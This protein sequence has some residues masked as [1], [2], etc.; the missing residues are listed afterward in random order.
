MSLK[1]Q[2][3]TGAKAPVDAPLRWVLRTAVASGQ[4][5]VWGTKLVI[6]NGNANLGDLTTFCLKLDFKSAAQGVVVY[7]EMSDLFP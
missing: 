2:W 4:C 7:A 1:R 3:M 5:F 6:R